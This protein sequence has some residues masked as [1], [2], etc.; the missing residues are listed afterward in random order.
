[1]KECQ[2]KISLLPERFEDSKLSSHGLRYGGLHE[3]ANNK[4]ASYSCCF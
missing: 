2:G 1:V 3:I 4:S